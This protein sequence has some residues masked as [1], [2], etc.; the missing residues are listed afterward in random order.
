MLE[1]MNFNKKK[2]L[3]ISK[4]F[5]FVGM[6]LLMLN[7]FKNK[8]QKQSDQH[9][10]IEEKVDSLLSLM[11][12]E[13]KIGQMSQ[14][15]HFADVTDDDIA[16][17]FIGSVIHTAGP[18][19]G[20]GA[21]GWQKRF[22]TLQKKA[23]STRL[24]IPLLFGV[25]AIHGQN[26]FEGATIFPH[27]IGL[28]AAGNATLVEEAAAITAREAQATGFNWTFSPCIAIPYNEKWGRVYEGF[29]ESTALT[30]KMVKASV[31]GYQGNLNDYPGNY[32]SYL[33]NNRSYLGNLS[34]YLT[35]PESKVCNF[36]K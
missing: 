12:L 4:T 6:G 17:K 29:S 27:N 19:P 10:I 13:E 21:A 3:I 23:L 15:R 26:T 25:D 16:T 31:R 22:I 36:L 24:G 30:Q 11:T 8:F 20:K 1:F 7:S 35:F 28:G 9:R 18:N 34:D 32:R 33:G 14:V 2:F 5:L